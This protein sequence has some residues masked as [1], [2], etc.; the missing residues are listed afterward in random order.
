[1]SNYDL[2]SRFMGGL[3]LVF[4]LAK[5]FTCYWVGF[6]GE[7]LLFNWLYEVSEISTEPSPPP[8]RISTVMITNSNTQIRTV[9]Q[10][11][12]DSIDRL[13]RL[14]NAIRRAGAEKRY[15]RAKEFE[16]IGEDGDDLGHVF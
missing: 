9:I 12:T 13:H 1:M 8:M 6:F 11:V 3:R 16:W 15:L 10:A 7:L 14:S 2:Y 4:H 5:P